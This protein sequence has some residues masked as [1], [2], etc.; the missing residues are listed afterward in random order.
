MK[1]TVTTS[2]DRLVVIDVDADEIVS[3]KSSCYFSFI[4]IRPSLCRRL[5][6]LDSD[7]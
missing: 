1:L 4:P 5:N 6:C 7:H 3:D 2:D